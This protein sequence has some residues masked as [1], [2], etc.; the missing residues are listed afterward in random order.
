MKEGLLSLSGSNAH[1]SKVWEFG[2]K[3]KKRK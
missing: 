2:I 1:Q 3:K